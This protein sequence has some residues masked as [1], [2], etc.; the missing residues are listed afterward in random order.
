MF[1]LTKQHRFYLY[2]QPADM[3]K[4]FDGLSGIVIN[5]M[6][7]DPIDGSVY[8]FLN[9]RR[10]RIKILVWD[11]DGFILYYKRLEKGTF[12]IPNETEA[13]KMSL[14]WEVLMLILQGISLQKISRR[15][16]YKRAS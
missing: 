2:S 1:G 12:E 13:D 9:R 5:K 4:G 7:M 3:R 6:A 16:R 8:L 10:N 11:L 14:S 15:K